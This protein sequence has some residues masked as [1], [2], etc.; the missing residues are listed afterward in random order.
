[1]FDLFSTTAY[2]QDVAM[3]VPV[4][5]AA[6]GPVMTWVLTM[7]GGMISIFVPLVAIWLRNYLGIQNTQARSQ[8]INGSIV[9]AAH[10]ADANMTAQNVGISEVGVDSPVIKNA[11]SYVADAHPDA[12]AATP[13]ATG[14]HIAEA[15]FAELNSIQI[16][17]RNNPVPTVVL[18]PVSAVR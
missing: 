3:V 10:L 1:M 8:M 14:E 16:S 18:S 11:V 15:I 6:V 13:Q 4:V 17:K 9:R 2:A 12:V 5:P 7:A